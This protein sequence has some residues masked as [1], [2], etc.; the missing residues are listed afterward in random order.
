MSRTRPLKRC[1]RAAMPSCKLS[2]R[3]SRQVYVRNAQAAPQLRLTTTCIQSSVDRNKRSASQATN[4]H[5]RPGVRRLEKGSQISALSRQVPTPILA[6]A[7]HHARTSFA[8][9]GGSMA[10]SRGQY[11]R[12]GLRC[13]RESSLGSRLCRL[14]ILLCF[15]SLGIFGFWH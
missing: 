2:S 3:R 8:S 15:Y 13:R 5:G 14:Q 12:A 11:A 7:E 1:A 6:V 9:A 10:R 4:A